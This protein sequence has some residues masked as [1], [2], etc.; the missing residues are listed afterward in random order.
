[1]CFT[2][3][4]SCAF[5][6][7]GLYAAYW[8]KTR[9][10]NNDLAIGVFFFFTMEFL[11]AIQYGWGLATSLND[12]TSKY[13][14]KEY[15][16]QFLTVCGFLHIC[17]QPYYCHV[18]NCALTK[19]CKYK[20]RYMV[21]KRLCLWGGFLLFM[22]LPLSMADPYIDNFLGESRS[23]FGMR[24]P[25]FDSMGIK[26]IENESVIPPGFTYSR[27]GI[28][29][30]STEWLRGDR[31]CTFKDAERMW[32]LGWSVPMAD[33]S[34]YVMGASIHS[35]LMFIPFF[36]LYEKPGMII[37]GLFLFFSGPIMAWLVSPYLME[38]ASIWCFVS[39]AEIATM[40]F[41]IREMLLTEFGKGQFK[42]LDGKNSKE[43]AKQ[44]KRDCDFFNVMAMP[45]NKKCPYCN[46]A[47][48][49]AIKDTK[50]AK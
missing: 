45:T 6:A 30:N 24:V 22:R 16:N 40:L 37:Q 32:H 11:Q 8:I 21:I 38:Q 3:S 29:S 48:Q 36:V 42:L 1:M 25:V 34:Y 35:F 43:D 31:L 50:K 18:I 20:D 17:L 12:F 26:T 49:K 10:N 28:A 7:I 9:T 5:S 27:N 13:S 4:M 46:T 15:L 23:I 47:G 39:I 14:C 2:G 41:I 44:E 33:P 19:S